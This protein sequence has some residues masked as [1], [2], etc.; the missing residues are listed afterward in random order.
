[1]DYIVPSPPP[2][3]QLSHDETSAIL[4][5][6]SL[7]SATDLST[8][9]LPFL[10]THLDLL[11]TPLLLPFS[12][13]TTPRQRTSI[14]GIKSRRLLYA[15]RDPKP[16]ELRADS[17]RLRWPLLWER[18][19]GNRLPPPSGDVEEEEDWVRES[20]LPGKEDAQHVKKLG[21]FLRGLAEEREMEGVARARR[22]ERRLDDVGEEFDEESDEEEDVEAGEEAQE[23]QRE[24]QRESEE[25]IPNDSGLGALEAEDDQD[26]VKRVFERRLLELFLDGM[27]TLSY[28]HIDFVEPPEGDPIAKRDAE[29][30]YFDDEEPSRTPNGHIQG[31]SSVLDSS[32]GEESKQ[33]GPGE[34]D[35]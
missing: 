6:L 10:A 18:L 2:P 20:F 30:K 22:E 15:N 32:M 24:Q 14:P 11:P 35:Y 5:Y 28:D 17:G 9:P 27:D 3:Q 25:P 7:P 33:N 29:D 26:E 13:I 34:Y 4:T 16:R 23:R 31:E 12:R 1:M 21:G 19:G 8:P